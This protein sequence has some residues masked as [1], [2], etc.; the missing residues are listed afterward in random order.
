MTPRLVRVAAAVFGAALF[1]I[2]GRLRAQ[3]QPDKDRKGDSR[4]SLDIGVNGKGVSFGDSKEWTGLRFNYR[5][6]RLV[7]ANGV[8]LTLWNPYENGAGRVNGLAIGLPL[9]GA[10]E[11]KGLGV[12]GFGFGVERR[13]SGI[14]VAGLGMGGGGDMRGIMLAGL[15]MGGGGDIS[16]IS[17]AGLGMGGGG[18][19]N[20]IAIGGL[21]AGMGGH[22]T[23]LFVG[24]LG[25][26]AGG[27]VKGI[28]IGGLGFGTGGN[29]RGAAI[30]G[31]GVGA[32]GTAKGLLVGG[33]GGGVGGDFTGIGIGGLGI[34]AGGDITGLV[35][36][37]LGAGF[38]GTLRGVGIGG[39]GI[40]G[41]RIRGLAIGGLGVGGMDV[42]GGVISPIMFRVEREGRFQGVA[43]AGYSQIKGRQEGWTIGVVNYAHDLRGAQIGLIN[44]AKSNP[45]ATRVLPI[46]NKNFSK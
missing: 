42:E 6:S 38:G 43:V 11:L 20:G 18:N 17:I 29:L 21:G 5:D 37:G 26:G 4:R 36:G 35:I 7:E 28:G 44:I 14:G 32:G 45:K 24:G 30:G 1:V 39:L 27:D 23:G 19:L 3:D 9:T 10:S 25:A 12:G 22:M 31:L 15:G 13:F 33:L 46:F 8:N 41:S 2:P 40:G 16:G 34:G